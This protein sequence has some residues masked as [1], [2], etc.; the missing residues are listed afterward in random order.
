MIESGQRA[1]PVEE[2]AGDIEHG[3]LA[4]E[5]GQEILLDLKAVRYESSQA[6]QEDQRAGATGQSGGLCV[7]E[8]DRTVVAVSFLT[9]QG[10]GI[11]EVA[12][13]RDRT[14]Q[15]AEPKEA[16]GQDQ[17]VGEHF[18]AHKRSQFGFAETGVSMGNGSA[19]RRQLSEAF[20][21]RWCAL[22]R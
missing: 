19:G 14:V 3:C 6:E 5:A 15:R 18:A 9:E 16:L 8:N 2:L 7:H 10:E 17:P 4:L 20:S 1:R 12:L 11:G 21:Q 22:L 13:E